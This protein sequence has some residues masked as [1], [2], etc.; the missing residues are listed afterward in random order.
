VK[1]ID[2]LGGTEILHIFITSEGDDIR[3]GATG[4]P[5]PGYEAAIFD[6]NGNR[7][8]PCTV[9][10]L[11][12]RGPVGCRYLDNPERQKA[13][14]QN[15]WNF[16]GDAY[17]CDEDGYYWYQARADDMIISAGYNISGPEVESVLLMHPAVQDC[18]V[19]GAPDGERG[20][21]VKAYVVLRKDVPTIAETVKTLQDFVKSEI[22]P[23][24]YPRKIEFIDALPRTES[25][26]VQRFVLRKRAAETEAAIAS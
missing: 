26:K 20:Q 16:T 25:G 9:G 1:L 6:E 15:G 19:V 3:P 21:V 14:V 24:K 2:G 10:R 5:I 13:Y 11:A 4:K 8:P 18:A 17:I 22:A 12:I 23:Y 7:V